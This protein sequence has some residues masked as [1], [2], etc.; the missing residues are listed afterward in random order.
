MGTGNDVGPIGH[1][2]MHVVQVI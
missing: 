2:V 1:L